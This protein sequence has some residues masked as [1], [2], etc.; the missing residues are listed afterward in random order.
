[1]INKLQLANYK[2]RYVLKNIIIEKKRIDNRISA[3]FHI[4]YI[5]IFVLFYLYY[6]IY[7]TL[8]ILLYWHYLY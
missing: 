6:L 5:T 3:S 2:L 8:F 4:I 7:I 1:M